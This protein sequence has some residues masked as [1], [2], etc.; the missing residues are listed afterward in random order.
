MEVSSTESNSRIQEAIWALSKAKQEGI[1]DNQDS[2]ALFVSWNTLDSYLAHLSQAFNGSNIRH[3]IAVK[4]QP[5]SAVLAHMAKQGFGLEAASLEEVMLA[6]QANAPFIV[7]DS[8]VK[9]PS[10]IDYCQQLDRPLLLNVNCLEELERLP[11]KPRFEV[12]IRINPQVDIDAP[13]LYQVSQNES[14]FGVPI[15]QREAILDAIEQYPVT[16]LHVH[17]G[18]SMKNMD[19]P[20]AAI[21]Q[22]L[23]LAK[24]ANER[25]AQSGSSRRITSMDIGGGL[26]P[27]QLSDEPSVMQ[28]YAQLIQSSVADDWGDFQWV[29]E[30]GQ[31]VH[32]YTGYAASDV[33]YA[34]QRDETRIAF[35]HLGADFLMRDAYTAPRG[36]QFCLLDSAGNPKASA[37]Q[38]HDLAGPLCFA[39]DYIG[40][41]VTL[42]KAESGDQL[43]IM[44]TGS[45]A[46]GL[47][48]RHCSRSIP[49]VL[50]VSRQADEIMVLSERDNF[51]RA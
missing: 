41:A 23:A 4:T 16:A 33:E 51:V 46:F 40:R 10:E 47:W 29:T 28:Q 7:F 11:E 31:W 14:K 49:K 15:T 42:P 45:N 43:L 20:V 34:L 17:S 22:L 36:L 26:S 1:L 9:R 21:M 37:P 19:A 30:F 2:S 44:N 39:G 6:E 24:E 38:K 8:P 25:L 3:S 13:E 12:G 48:S 35:L 32:F 5:H 27:E 50:G 18:S